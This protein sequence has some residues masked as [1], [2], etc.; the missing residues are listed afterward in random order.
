MQKN[1]AIQY[2]STF[3]RKL[4][5]STLAESQKIFVYNYLDVLNLEYSDQLIMV[6]SNRQTND[7]SSNFVRFG[8]NFGRITAV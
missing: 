6:H 4:H 8:C 3:F 2:Q 1:F 5:S 7:V